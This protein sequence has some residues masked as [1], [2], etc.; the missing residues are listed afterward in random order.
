M[1]LAHGPRTRFRSG[2]G[3]ISWQSVPSMAV[4]GRASSRGPR[5]HGSR[6]DR[7]IGA[8]TRRL[9]AGGAGRICRRHSSAGP[10]QTALPASG[11]GHRR[12]VPDQGDEKGEAQGCKGHA[13]RLRPWWPPSGGVVGQTLGPERSGQHDGL[14]SG[15]DDRHEAAVGVAPAPC[16]STDVHGVKLVLSARGINPLL[17]QFSPKVAFRSRSMRLSTHAPRTTAPT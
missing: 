10:T 17:K 9:E 8:A 6:R 4:C 1:H 2:N 15:S 3:S 5:K 16:S 11:P 14:G 13:A 12:S 7:C